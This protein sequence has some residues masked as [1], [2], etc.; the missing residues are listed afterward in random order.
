MRLGNALSSQMST[1]IS[2][3]SLCE[4]EL[5]CANPFFES[6][7][8]PPACL[9]G[10]PASIFGAVLTHSIFIFLLAAAE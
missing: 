9:G 10:L 1:P 7:G 2:D 5:Q 8:N 4:P 3:R 6:D